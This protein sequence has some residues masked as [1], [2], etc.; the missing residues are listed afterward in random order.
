MKETSMRDQNLFVIVILYRHN[1]LINLHIILIMGGRRML[2]CA[3]ATNDKNG[4]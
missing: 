1:H 4:I 2:E 3:I